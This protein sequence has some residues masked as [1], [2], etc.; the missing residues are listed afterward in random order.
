M[1][2]PI[3]FSP[4]KFTFNVENNRH[5]C[6]WVVK[7]SWFSWFS[8]FIMVSVYLSFSQDNF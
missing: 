3:L 1:V 2:T 7:Y 5:S 4:V 8:W 6:A